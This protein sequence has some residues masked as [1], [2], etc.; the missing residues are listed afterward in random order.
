MISI[1]MPIYNGI[2]F[3]QESVTSVL[4]QTF[5]E[6]ELL[7]AIN[8]HPK[9]SEIY[10]LAKKYEEKSPRIRVFDFYTLKGKSVTLNKMVQH[11]KFDY[12]AIL[13]VDDIWYPLKLEKQ[14]PY[15]DK[16]DVIGT[17]C[18]Y[19]GDSQLNEVVPNIPTGNISDFNFLPINPII[20]SSSLIKKPLCYWNEEEF[21][22][23]EDY[24][25][26]LRLRNDNHTFYNVYEILVKHRIHQQSAFN[27]S[28]KQLNKL[29]QRTSTHR[30]H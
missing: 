26:W 17:K 9:N 3:I 20:N 18:I 22:S 15:I 19:F 6:W 16:Y 10:Q 28:E 7:I 14:L 23:I 4:D 8:G 13:D 24:D 5:T 11:C 27:S 21:D 12:I 30:I 2:E 25:L 1:L 29:M